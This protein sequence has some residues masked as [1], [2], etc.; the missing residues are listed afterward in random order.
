MFRYDSLTMEQTA[1]TPESTMTL[2]KRAGS[3]QSSKTIT[4]SVRRKREPAPQ[5]SL[6][7]DL[8]LP[9]PRYRDES[10]APEVDRELLRKL[11]RDE[12]PVKTM[13]NVFRLVHCFE[14]WNR[15]YTAALVEEQ[16]RKARR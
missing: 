2:R 9:E 10:L 11:V 3:K 5:G 7:K 6:W 15:A 12:L 8:G 4:R 14:S 16:R 13:R 1:H